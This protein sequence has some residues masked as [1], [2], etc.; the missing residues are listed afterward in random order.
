MHL[1]DLFHQVDVALQRLDLPPHRRQA[2]GT[3]QKIPVRL[4]TSTGR[5]SGQPRISPLYFL[6]E[7][8]RVVVAASQSG[9]ENNP[10]W[11]LNLKADPKVRVQIRDEVLQLT[12]RDA[13]DE[14]RAQYWRKLVEMYPTY[15]D[16]QSWTG[17]VIPIVI[18][19]P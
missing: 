19:D 16:Y 3:F 9:R 13:T 4:L 11:Y 7:G 15:A 17:R 8:G 5:K 18:C 1:G 2:G 12:A 6:C 10:M 14:E